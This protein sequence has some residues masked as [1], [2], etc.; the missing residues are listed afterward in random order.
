MR[1]RFILS[2][3]LVAG[4]LVYSPA[5]SATLCPDTGHYYDFVLSYCNQPW[6]EAKNLAE[7]A[8]GY[9]A[10]VTSAAEQLCMATIQ[11]GGWAAYWAGASDAASEGQ[12]RWVTGPEGAE[13]GGAGRQFWQGGPAQFGGTTTTPDFYANWF[14]P[15]TYAEPNNAGNEDYMSWNAGGGIGSFNNHWNDVPPTN[16]AVCG[17]TVEWDSDPSGPPDADGDGVP[18]DSDNCPSDPNPGQEDNDSDGL[19]DVCDADDDNDGVD[20]PLDNC[21]T[22]ANPGQEDYD[23]DGLGNVCDPAF[24]GDDL[25]L[26]IESL[27]LDMRDLIVAVDPPGGNGMI[28]KLTGKGGVLAKAANAI[29]A[30]GAG[31]IGVDGYLE[32]LAETLDMLSAF[33]NQLEA[34]IANGQVPAVTEGDDLVSLSGDIRS[35]IEELISAAGG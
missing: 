29:T 34:K 5:R 30:F 1:S 9:L 14:P 23:L 17:Y 8:G 13:N 24:G 31:L 4:V 11:G 27:V 20:D 15:P 6:S 12:W 33:D 10:T 16:S 25:V 28:N 21:P 2:L 3:L 19:G 7:A 18:D 26:T 32:A 22:D 35:L